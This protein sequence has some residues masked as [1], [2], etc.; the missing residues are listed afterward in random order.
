VMSSVVPATSESTIQ[1]GKRVAVANAEV[2][3][4]RDHGH[5]SGW[6]QR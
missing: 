1:S 4:S 3:L 2:G 6:P 5:R